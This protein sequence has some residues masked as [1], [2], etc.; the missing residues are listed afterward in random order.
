M[1]R[2]WIV[3]RHSNDGGREEDGL[4]IVEV[5]HYVKGAYFAYGIDY[6][7]EGLYRIYELHKWYGEDF[8]E[9]D[10]YLPI[11]KGFRFPRYI[12]K[13]IKALAKSLEWE[14]RNALTN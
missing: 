11:P 13:E 3:D 9:V 6:D 4:R 8:S 1:T 12:E 14:K 7:S 5:Q 2:R 10:E